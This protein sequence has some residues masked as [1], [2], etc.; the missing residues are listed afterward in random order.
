MLDLVVLVLGLAAA[1]AALH[2]SLAEQVAA[3]QQGDRH[4]AEAIL[5]NDPFQQ[6]PKYF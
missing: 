2:F 5:V 1:V 3:D 6:E 4:L